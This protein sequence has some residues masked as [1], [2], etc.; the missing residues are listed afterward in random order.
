M[1]ISSLKNPQIQLIKSLYTAKGR[2]EH[3]AFLA[4]GEHL[5]EEAKQYGKINFI[6]VSEDSIDKYAHLL[7]DCSTLVMENKLFSRISET[8]SPQGICAVCSMESLPQTSNRLVLLNAVQD[9]G[10]V[11]TIIRTA[12][13]AGFDVILDSHCA[14]IYNPKVIRST[15]GSLFHVAC[16]KTCS[17]LEYI[18]KLQCDGFAI[19]AAVLDGSPFYQRATDPEKIAL[20]IGNEGKGMDEEIQSLCSH[21]FRLPMLGKA[22]SLNAGVAAGILMYD[23]LRKE[24]KNT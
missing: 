18:P 5:V 6:A 10:N 19:Y 1:I 8:I 22:E 17:L 24:E 4:E 20:I 21:K 23:I 2:A 14:D 11:G 13:A 3:K 15:M 7:H 16:T 12:D 9:P